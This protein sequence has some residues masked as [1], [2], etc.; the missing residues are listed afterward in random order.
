MGKKLIKGGTLIDGTGKQPIKDAAVLIE[1]EK[2]A[3]CPT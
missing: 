1:G 3:G 2:I